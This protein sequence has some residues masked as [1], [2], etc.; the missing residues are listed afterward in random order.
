[1]G[2]SG[3][4]RRHERSDPE[5]LD[6]SLHV[7]GQDVEAHLGSGLFD[8]PGQEV[9]AS[10]PRFE[11]PEGMLDGLPAHAHGAWHVVEPGLHPVED[12][13]VLPAPEPLELVGRALWLEPT[14]EAGR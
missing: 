3:S 12:G 4:D 2:W 6:H 7:V 1:M 11:G 9:G 14:G 13:L 5:D 8:G 10:H